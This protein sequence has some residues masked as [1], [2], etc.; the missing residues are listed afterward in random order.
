M[1]CGPERL[2]VKSRIT[3]MRVYTE[4]IYRWD[5]AKKR[6]V[7]I[8]ENGF[9]YPDGAPSALAKGPTSAQIEL[10]TE[11]ASFYKEMTKDYATQ[12]AGQQAILGTL[13]SAWAPI[14]AAGPNQYGFSAAQDATLRAQAVEGTAQT[15]QQAE[16]AVNSGIA[17][18]GAGDTLPSGANEQLRQITANAAA[19]TTSKE[20]LGI[21]GAGYQQGYNNFTAATNALSGVAAQ[22]NPLGYAGAATSAGSAE[23]QT[24]QAIAQESGGIWNAIGGIVGGFA[25]KIAGGVGASLT[26]ADLPWL[27]D[28]PPWLQ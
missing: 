14:L 3:K 8:Y 19:A 23:G 1:N 22:D 25:G 20:Q 28:P 9:D 6:C 24:A 12:F 4:S 21:T 16:Q 7:L 2:F 13:T 27:Q 10:Q 18:R 5:E 26:R 15:Y 11:Q 17:S